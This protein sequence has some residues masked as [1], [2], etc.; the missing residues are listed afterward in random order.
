MRVLKSG[1][2]GLGWSHELVCTGKGN[3]T[4]G[5]GCDAMLLVSFSDLFLTFH[6]DYTGEAEKYVTFEC[7][8]CHV[9]TDLDPNI[10]PRNPPVTRRGVMRTRISRTGDG[11]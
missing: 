4:D 10:E 6:Y 2:G 5:A 8:E 11:R 3:E 1:R 7:P 9:W